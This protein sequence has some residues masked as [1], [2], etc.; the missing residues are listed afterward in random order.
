M[1]KQSFSAITRTAAQTRVLDAALK[2]IAEHGVSGT[3][4]QMI[5][6]TM[7][8]TKAAV[9]RQF[10]TKE[11]IVIAITEREMS[12][13][14]D[15]LEAAEAAGNG[16][17]SREILLD[18]MIDQAIERRGIVSV[19]QFDPVII[20]LQAEHKPFQRFIERLYATLLGTEAGPEARLHAAMLSS[21][22]SVAVMHPLVADLDA[23]TLR[24]QLIR[25]SGRMLDLPER[26]QGSARTAKR[27][28]AAV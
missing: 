8:V 6:D 2:L 19:L 1:A 13:L 14:E 22:I 10:K 24:A 11:E 4:L 23:E 3:S 17:R 7:G 15:A 21:A 27:R 9:Y 25:M 16:L 12:R 28:S 20:R 18:R 26:D 5:A